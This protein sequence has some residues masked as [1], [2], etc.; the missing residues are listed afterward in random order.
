MAT[1]R[2]HATHFTRAVTA[3]VLVGAVVFALP[4][5]QVGRVDELGPI[6]RSFNSP[7]EASTGMDTAADGI[8][9]IA[10]DPAFASVADLA[11]RLR[12]AARA[13]RA[14]DEIEPVLSELTQVAYELRAASVELGNRRL[15]ELSVLVGSTHDYLKNESEITGPLRRPEPTVPPEPADNTFAQALEVVGVASGAVVAL[16]TI[17]TTVFG[18][19]IHQSKKKR[20]NEKHAS[21]GQDGRP[22]P[23]NA[24]QTSTAGD[25]TSRTEDAHPD[26]VSATPVKGDSPAAPGEAPGPD[27]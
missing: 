27:P 22:S 23:D 12:D 1:P 17:A 26:G 8:E 11:G 16:A 7:A 25:S 5:C 4:A 19:V 15:N 20:R 14:G 10:E 2:R 13:T 24:T 6:V 9:E 3:L 21:P 18:I